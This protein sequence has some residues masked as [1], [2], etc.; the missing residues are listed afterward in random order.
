MGMKNKQDNVRAS[1]F[2]PATS[3]KTVAKVAGGPVDSGKGGKR[4]D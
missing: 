3:M 2:G 4:K 1:T